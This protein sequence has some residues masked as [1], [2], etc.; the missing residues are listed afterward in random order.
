MIDNQL[1]SY[2]ELILYSGVGKASCSARYDDG[3]QEVPGGEGA[4]YSWLP[5]TLTIQAI[6]TTHIWS[7]RMPVMLCFAFQPTT[8]SLLYI[9]FLE[10]VYCKWIEFCNAEPYHQQQY[11]AL[12]LLTVKQHSH[13]HQ[14]T[15]H[16]RHYN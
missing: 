8:V 15:I 10:Q 13:S 2:R 11:M 5:V 1:L 4:F 7:H 12:S 6:F 16:R 3:F 9:I 14:L